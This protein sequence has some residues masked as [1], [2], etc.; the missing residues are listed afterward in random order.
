MTARNMA[1][2]IDRR[3][4]LK[5]GSLTMAA[6]HCTG[7]VAVASPATVAV[8][9]AAPL[10]SPCVTLH[11]GMPEIDATGRAAPYVQDRCPGAHVRGHGDWWMP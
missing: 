5:S 7:I 1:D 4:F 6:L 2:A 11:M 8:G 10:G 3:T 9:A